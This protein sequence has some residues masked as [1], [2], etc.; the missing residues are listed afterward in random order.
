MM[1]SATTVWGT[2]M[3]KRTVYS[4]PPPALRFTSAAH[5]SVPSA[6]ASSVET[7]AI[8]RLTHSALRN[9]GRLNTSL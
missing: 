8:L 1:N 5:S 7:K 2:S 3:G 9:S 6:A 4:M